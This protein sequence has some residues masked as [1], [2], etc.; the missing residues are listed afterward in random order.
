MGA[1]HKCDFLRCL[2]MKYGDGYS[3]FYGET[4]AYIRSDGCA[5]GY[6]F[7]IFDNC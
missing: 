6:V 2:F 4:P 1:K 7:S 3:S 5:I